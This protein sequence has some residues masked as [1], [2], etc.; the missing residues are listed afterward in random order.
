MPKMYEPDERKTSVAMAQ[1]CDSTC[2]AKLR[3]GS[4]GNMRELGS[5]LSGHTSRNAQ[6][7]KTAASSMEEQ[8]RQRP[9]P[10]THGRKG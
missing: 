5:T 2:A 4:G 3:C 6:L 7:Q 9:H 10:K 1:D 8:L